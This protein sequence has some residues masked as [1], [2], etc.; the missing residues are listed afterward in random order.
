M[1]TEVGLRNWLETE[2]KLC[3]EE[4]IKLS[5]EESKHDPETEPYKSKYAARE[6]LLNLNNKVDSFVSDVDEIEEL[7][8]KS[9]QSVINY[10]LG[11]N[12]IETDE[13]STG[14]RYLNSIKE[15]NEE[16]KLNPEFCTVIVKCLQQLGML[17][18]ERGDFEKS[19]GYFCE[20]EA[21][22]HEYKDL[23]NIEPFNTDM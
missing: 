7:R 12:Y 19:L 8:L 22:F 16:F 23:S 9:L 2:G 6:I 21:L 3:F 18:N 17:W 13:I 20:A 15:K 11:V 5:K 1:A 10:E 4:A 14:E